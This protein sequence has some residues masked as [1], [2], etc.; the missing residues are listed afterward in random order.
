MR[1]H[2]PRTPHL[3]WSPGLS[4]DDVRAEGVA[5]LAGR[6]VVVTE[7]LDGENTTLYGDGLHARSL[8]SG[9]HPSRAWLKAL[10][11]RIARFI[12][13]GWRI[14]G[15][16]LYARHSIAYPSLDS[17]FSAFSVW[18]GD[19]CLDWDAT[20]D[21]TRRLGL[22]VPPV[23]W[24]GV[25][26]ERAIRAL[27]LDVGRQ[28]GYVVRPA[29]AF[30]RAEFPALVAKWVRPRHVRTDRHWMLGP[31]VENG[32]SP[33]AALW[34]T[35]SGATPD[36]PALEKA[37]G[38]T[39][40][41]AESR[42]A[43][44]AARLDQIGRTGDARLAGVLA[45]LLADRH[46]SRL[47][48]QLVAPLGMALARRV[49][50]LVGLAPTLARPLP[51][52]SIRGTLIRY[53]AAADLGVLH[54]VA[55][56]GPGPREPVEWAQL[57]AEEEGLL[58]ERPLHE[59]RTG[60]LS[61]G[62][63]SPEAADRCWGEARE[64]YARGKVFSAAEAIALTWRWR[65]GDFPQVI[66]TVGPSGSGKS[67]FARRFPRVVSLDDLRGERGSRANQRDNPAVLNEGLRRLDALLAEGGT[68]V[69]D[70]TALNRHQRSLV[71]AVA[72]G[73]DALITHAVALVPEETLARRNAVRADPV[74][75]GVLDAQ[76]RRF[77]PPYP[78]EGHRTW[79]LGDDGAVQD[80]DGG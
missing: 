34:D 36:I 1:V 54:A 39:G 80:R 74:P 76:L 78:G 59:L 53:C 79:Y 77:D 72:R 5:G 42:V 12:P 46:R 37:I 70:A 25:F 45:V 29:A 20:V 26:D 6:E 75:A 11:G 50:D 21:F 44:V 61:A 40:E 56:A 41:S 8:D 13:D 35:R 30:T 31:V 17:W 28:E 65:S 51:E 14:C 68:V 66:I 69:W 71:Q 2:Y 23:L 64:A 4:A 63:G 67:T 24:R 7:K 47:G 3:P 48:P 60:L 27:R 32:L 22:P 57:H 15:E 19:L 49:A 73:R 10:H 43:E 16:N 62:P 38:L 33:A 55:L 9:H 18:N 58:G 52:E